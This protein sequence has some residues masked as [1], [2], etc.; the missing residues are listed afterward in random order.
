MPR[1]SVKQVLGTLKAR[2]PRD[3]GNAALAKARETCPVQT[4]D[5]YRSLYVEINADGFELGATV[6]YASD[7]EEGT[8]PVNVGGSWTGTWKR[9]KRRTKNGTTTIG[10]HKKTFKGK[11]PVKVSGQWRTLSSS[12]GREGTFFMK[13]A[14]EAAIEENIE[15]ILQ[16][17]GA[18]KTK[19]R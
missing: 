6:L 11:K 12:P 16:S 19:P 8:Q 10:K 2:L 15:K 18:S 4:G 13:K 7:I 9:H 17:L 1:T 5:L 14:L 3:I